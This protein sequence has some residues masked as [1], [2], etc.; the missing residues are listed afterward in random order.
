VS[1]P[2]ERTPEDRRRNVETKAVRRLT[3]ASQWRIELAHEL[4][5][6]YST[7]PGIKMMVL[8]GSPPKGLSDAFSDL[9]L[10]AFWDTIDGDWI[11]QEP[12]RSLGYERA[13]YRKMGE[14]D[15]Y[16][17]SYYFDELK[18]DLGHIT[19]DGWKKTVDGVLGDLDTSPSEQSQLGGFLS[20]LPLHG[21]DLVE[22]WRGRVAAYPD[23]LATKMVKSNMRFYVCGYLMNQ[24]FHRGE[25]LAYHDGIC[26]MLKN[27]LNVLSG[28]NKMYA[29][30]DEP[31][32][33]AYYLEQMSI[34]PE[35]AWERMKVALEETGEAGIESLEGLID[36][37][38]G[39]IE[40]HMPDIDVERIRGGRKRMTVRG[41]DT[42]P[43]IPV[44]RTSGEA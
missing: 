19:M 32:W 29:F 43:V 17:E 38:L 4:T 6:F 20:S 39:L 28:L 10:I 2:G 9:D 31:R 34:C 44:S 35:N 3:P 13:Y 15:T 24:V 37:V 23:E 5:P 36:G 40:K 18:V 22:E 12:L 21:H 14:G 26:T 27:L 30:T 8:S 33:A 42:K 41:R 16:L 7:H 11:E 1:H 25:V